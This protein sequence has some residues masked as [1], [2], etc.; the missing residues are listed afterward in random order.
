M[1]AGDIIRW[2]AALLLVSVILAG[3]GASVGEASDDSIAA[4]VE[5]GRY[6]DAYEAS[7]QNG[8]PRPAELVRTARL[9]LN[10]GLK[11][12]DS[13][14]RWFA[15]RA[16][17]TLDDPM[18]ATSARQL[19]GSGDRYVRSLALEI[20][21]RTDPEGS[22]DDFL[23]ALES[24]FRSVRLRALTGLA[25][26]TDPSLVDRFANIL[27]NDP[28]PDLRALAVQA[29]GTTGSTQAMPP[30]REAL[31][32]PVDIV[33]EEAVQ[34]L[35]ALGDPEISKL[36]RNRLA[37]ATPEKSVSIVRMAALVPDSKLLE[38]LG[39]FLGDENPEVRAFAAAAVL[40]IA[41]RTMQKK[42]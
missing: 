14:P 16:T 37:E 33:R 15:L 22:R 19:A 42:P 30:L 6:R 7:L 5:Q 25:K 31:D 10:A 38:A 32:D 28:D 40:S 36:V 24:P 11:S 39:P 8:E 41:Q 23:A 20:L 17:R 26:L 13:Y 3:P 1:T 9:L 27:R 35:V 18:L 2:Q 34:A 29:L 4:L 21:A 12:P